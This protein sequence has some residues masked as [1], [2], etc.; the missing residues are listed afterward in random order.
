MEKFF[1]RDYLGEYVVFATA[2]N[3]GVTSQHREWIPNTITQNHSGHAIVFGNGPSRKNINWALFKMHRGGINAS[4]K[5][6]TYGCNAMYRDCDP[7]FLVVKHPLVADEI[8]ATNYADSN[9]VI[10]TVKNTL[11]HKDKFHIIPFDPNLCAGATAL[12]LA[13]FDDHKKVYFMGFDG[14]ERNI[15]NNV[16][17]GTNGYGTDRTEVNAQKQIDDVMKVFNTYDTTEFIRVSQYGTELIPEEWKYA[18]NLRCISYNEF[19]SE[20]DLGV[21]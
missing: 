10:T 9:V 19:V 8:A 16:Y 2:K 5:L 12:Y 21:T 14:Y 17:A 11:K 13:A 7:H 6:T 18:Q 3:K 15:N 20:I 4:K 1:R